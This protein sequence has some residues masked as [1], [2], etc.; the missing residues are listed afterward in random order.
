MTE[1]IDTKKKL[2]PVGSWVL[3]Y[4]EKRFA[5]GLN[6]FVARSGYVSSFIDEWLWESRSG[7][8]YAQ[9]II[10]GWIDIPEF[11]GFDVDEE[12]DVFKRYEILDFNIS[13]K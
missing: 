5:K 9:S 6:I 7:E 12:K 13:Q 11:E 8:I 1:W 4:C 2:P 10:L 3:V